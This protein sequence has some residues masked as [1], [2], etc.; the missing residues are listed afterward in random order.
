MK[1]G[2]DRPLGGQAIFQGA[3]GSRLKVII[4]LRLGILEFGD[5]IFCDCYRPFCLDCSLIN[6]SRQ[7]ETIFVVG[8][9]LRANLLS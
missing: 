9:Q 1:T 2:E 8:I 4:S 7:V 3:V 5:F 6:G